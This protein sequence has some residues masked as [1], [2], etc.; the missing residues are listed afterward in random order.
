MS[1]INCCI[2][3]NPNAAAQFRLEPRLRYVL[4]AAESGFVAAKKDAEL[5][6]NSGDWLE[7][8]SKAGEALAYAGM[9]MSISEAAAMHLSDCATNN[10]PAYKSGTCDCGALHAGDAIKE[11]A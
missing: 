1:E 3:G 9:K 4:Q 2:D 10:S 7:Y 6:K 5:A 11:A 8:Y